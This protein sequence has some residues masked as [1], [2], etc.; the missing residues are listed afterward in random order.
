MWSKLKIKQAFVLIA[1]FGAFFSSLSAQTSP[2][3]NNSNDLKLGVGLTTLFTTKQVK[4]IEYQSS[5]TLDQNQWS[6]MS[7]P[8]VTVGLRKGAF[9]ADLNFNVKQFLLTLGGNIPIT[10][11]LKVSLGAGIWNYGHGWLEEESR[12][13]DNAKRHF[14]T[15]DWG[16]STNTMA[17]GTFFCGGLKYQITQKLSAEISYQQFV[18]T[19]S[20]VKDNYYFGPN[21]S[22]AGWNEFNIKHPIMFGLKWEF[23]TLLRN[24]SPNEI[25]INKGDDQTKIIYQ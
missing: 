6:E 16:Y 10:K 8:C 12:D 25:H 4:F 9:N 7:G 11:N 17:L 3:K 1:N 18:N 21:W 22:Q 2:E 24:D 19:P 5:N 13:N 15:P 23:P 14:G 20:Y